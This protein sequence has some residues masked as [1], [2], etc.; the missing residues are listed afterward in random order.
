ME[1]ILK[2]YQ[3]GITA[4]SFEPEIIANLLNQTTAEDWD[5]MKHASLQ[6]VKTLNADNEMQTLLELY[7]KYI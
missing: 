6:A 4:P 7:A 1:K 3:C 5:T 2:E